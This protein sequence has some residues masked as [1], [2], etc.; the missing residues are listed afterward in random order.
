MG[1]KARLVL[2]APDE[3]A[4]RRAARLAFDRMHRL[5]DVMSDWR[6]DTE[7]MLVHAAPP[8]VEIPVSHDLH[9]VLRRSRRI[10]ELTDGAFDVS[11]G[12]VVQLWRE[13]RRSG[14]MPEAGALTAARARVGWDLYRVGDEEDTVTLL[15][16]DMR[17]DLGGIGKG[18]AAD[19][20]ALALAD[21]GVRSA[22]IDIG[23][24]L[25]V[26]APPPGRRA[27]RVTVL[28]GDGETPRMTLD[29]ANE[30]VATSGDTE[31]SVE[32][33]GLQ[34]SH[35]VDPRTG[36]GLTT[37]AAATVVAPD[38]ATADALA[39]ALCVAGP[40]RTIAIL[41]TFGVEGVLTVVADGRRLRV[42]QIDR[43][44]EDDP[45]PTDWRWGGSEWT[46]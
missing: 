14:Q 31:Q 37:H 19:Q 1:V 39:S 7:L 41:R 5:D 21:A 16:P 18:Y 22:L 44:M 35:I 15:A 32:I 40:D 25:R 43:R 20:A 36:L 2:Y 28:T 17:L 27:W 4:A 46:P 11:V 23:G 12:P 38:G 10:S 34:Y 26:T 45:G 13:A 3:E 30:A 33:D 8:G 9:E 42:G 6:A 29:L 24:D